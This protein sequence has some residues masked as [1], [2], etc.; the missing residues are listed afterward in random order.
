MESP[1]PASSED[2]MVINK[3]IAPGL[4]DLK[5]FCHYIVFMKVLII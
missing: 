1:A 3:D 4:M 5:W 2:A